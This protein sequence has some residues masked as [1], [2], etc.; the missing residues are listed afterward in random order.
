MR[1]SGSIER[2]RQVHRSI[3]AL[4]GVALLCVF[5]A[6]M[7]PTLAETLPAITAGYYESFALKWDGTVWAWGQN[8]QGQ[9]G[10]GSTWRPSPFQLS[11][12]SNVTAI[13]AGYTHTVA[14][15]PDGTVWA[16]GWNTFG[17]LGDGQQPP[18]FLQSKSI[19]L[20]TSRRLQPEKITLWH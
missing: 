8:Q 12:L 10:N 15:K 5:S 11:F 17:Q 1:S 13:A 6:T 16:W 18:A 4:V 9:L 19:P 14:L 3:D 7:F 20:A 2:N